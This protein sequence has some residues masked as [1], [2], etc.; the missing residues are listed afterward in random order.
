M[1]TTARL[2]VT[3]TL[4]GCGRTPSNTHNEMRLKKDAAKFITVGLTFY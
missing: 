1:T 2:E 4:V 3:F